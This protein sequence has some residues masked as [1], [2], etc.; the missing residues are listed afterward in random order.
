MRDVYINREMVGMDQ[1]DSQALKKGDRL[2]WSE[3]GFTRLLS[4]ELVGW[5]A[6]HLYS[7][8]PWVR[9]SGRSWGETRLVKEG[10]ERNHDRG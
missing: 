10:W 8:V 9:L 6:D 7:G 2:S 1:E 4:V 3:M 5:L